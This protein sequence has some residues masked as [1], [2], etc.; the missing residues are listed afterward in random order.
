MK[1]VFSIALS[2]KK[3]FSVIAIPNAGTGI[4]KFQGLVN[5]VPFTQSLDYDR[6]R[7]KIMK[8]VELNQR[9]SG[10]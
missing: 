6:V 7:T 8:A 4:T 1:Q 2:R 5:G 3:E 10:N 9:G